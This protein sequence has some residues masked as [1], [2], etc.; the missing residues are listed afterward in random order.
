MKIKLISLLIV[1][2]YFSASFIIS[3]G[4]NKSIVDQNSLLGKCLGF[5]YFLSEG[6]GFYLGIAGLV[7]SLIILG[8]II[9]FLLFQILTYLKSKF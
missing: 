7:F 4:S 6:V 9:W 1:I 5:P 2:A 3:S 8:T